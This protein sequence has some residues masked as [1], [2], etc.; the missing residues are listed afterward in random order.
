MIDK[1][2]GMCLA[3]R[4]LYVRWLVARP[5]AIGLG[6]ITQARAGYDLTPRGIAD[7]RKARYESWRNLVREQL[8]A[9]VANCK[10]G[11]H[12]RGSVKTGGRG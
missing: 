5:P 4:E 7:R 3:C 8:A 9:I 10:A 12:A 2:G 11:R 6:W 1:S